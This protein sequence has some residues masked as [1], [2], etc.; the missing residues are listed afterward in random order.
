MMT[1]TVGQYL[2][3]RLKDYGVRHV[4]GVPGD[5]NLEFL[6]LIEDDPGLEWVGNCNELNGA[7]A[8]DGYGRINSMAALVT[9][10]GVGE[11][12]AIN[13][14]AGSYAESV[15]VVKIV[16]MPSRNASINRRYMHHTLG[17]GEFMKFYDMYRAITVARTVLNKQ[18]AKSEID[19]VLA[20]CALHKKPVY[21][22]IPA[23]VAHL[24]IDVSTPMI[25][26]PKSDKKIL[27]SF[28]EAVEQI[29]KNAKAP[30]VLADYEIKR[31]KLQDELLEFIQKANLPIATLAMGKGAFPETHPNF[32]G[33]Y[34]GIL[35][36]ERVTSM[37]REKDC[38]I[39]LGVKFTDFLTAGFHYINTTPNFGVPVIEVHP[40][41]SQIGQK[42]Y[43]DILMADVLKKLATLKYSAKM[44]PAEKREHTKLSGK[45]TQHKFFQVIEQHLRPKD[46]LLTETGTSFF[47]SIA[48]H[49]PEKV[50]F[51]GQPLWGSIGFTFGALLG[52]CLADRERRNILIIGDGS[53]QLTAQELSTMLRENL[54]PIIIVINN[55]GYTVERCIHGPN[56]K[57]NDIN[58]WHY[59]KL[60]EVFDVHL[61]RHAF[62][63]TASSVEELNHAL[64]EADKSK[65]L[66]FI[67]VIMDRDDAP[68]LLKKLGEIASKNNQQ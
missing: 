50:T 27:D 42:V 36:D 9:T 33:I 14:I 43:S 46:V 68:V 55:D 12:S 45:L 67:E 13:G 39:L 34:S 61:K 51:V 54:T 56:R 20:E 66:S 63:A 18:N 26:K 28:I 10:F 22:G 47:G 58:M 24:S 17:D 62:S 57:Y 59:T 41:Y 11:L 23:D 19:R 37:A 35:S 4:F 2:L 64:E 49:L 52:T 60:V 1:T 53:F 7:Y 48:I 30:L 15:P 16:G 21:I 65:K 29:I 32:I 38:L 44:P 25:Y 6:D 5:Y 8:S 31:Y 3:D 40:L